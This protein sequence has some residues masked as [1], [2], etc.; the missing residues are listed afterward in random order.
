MQILS[1]ENHGYADN[2]ALLIDKDFNIIDKDDNIEDL[3]DNN[4]GIIL[5]EEDK[6]WKRD[7]LPQLNA[8][9]FKNSE[10]TIK[11]LKVSIDKLKPV[12]NERV[13]GLVKKTIKMLKSGKEKPIVVDKFGYIVNGHHRYD[14]YT[15]LGVKIVPVLKVNATIEELIDK[16]M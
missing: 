16:Y 9:N 13:R 5:S 1:G 4:F 7:E 3:L 8:K 12:Q 14:A 2:V 10:Y 11:E 6:L 15:K